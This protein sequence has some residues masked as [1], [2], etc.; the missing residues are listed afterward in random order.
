MR[1]TGFCPLIITKDP[2]GVVK[3]FEDMGFEKRHTKRDIEGGAN[4]TYAMKDAFGNRIN[5]TSSETVPKDMTSIT[6]NVD[7]FRE[8]YDFLIAHGFSD[9][10]GDKVTETSSSIATMLFSPTG[11]PVTVSEH[12]KALR[13][14]DQIGDIKDDPR[15]QKQLKVMMDVVAA[16]FRNNMASYIKLVQMDVL[17]EFNRMCDKEGIGGERVKFCHGIMDPV[18]MQINK[19]LYDKIEAE[20]ELAKEQL[21][22]SE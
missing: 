13:Y 20:F 19:D 11:I 10:R 8:A 7:D 5:I 18:L 3:L 12:I 9:P 22:R 17:K 15:S 4:T 6:M 2:E 16:A 1:I 14:Q 21:D